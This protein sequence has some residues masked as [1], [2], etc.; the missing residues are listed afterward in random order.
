VSS[1]G[2]GTMMAPPPPPPPPQ[3]P[4]TLKEELHCSFCGSTKHSIEKC[5]H[6]LKARKAMRDEQKAAE[7]AK[8]AEKAAE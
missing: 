1:P 2:Q 6:M 5:T 7:S 3:L 8:K 4:P